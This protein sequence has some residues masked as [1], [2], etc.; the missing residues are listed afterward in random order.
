MIKVNE[1]TYESVRDVFIIDLG[2]SNRAKNC[3]LRSGI[4]TVGQLLEATREELIK[5]PNMG[6]GSLTEIETRLVQLIGQ[7][8]ICAE[9]VPDENVF[10]P[11]KRP[12]LDSDNE[13]LNDIPIEKLGL[14]AR[15]KH[16]LAHEGVKF[17]GQLRDIYETDLYHIQGMGSGSIKEIIDAVER[18]MSKPVYSYATLDNIDLLDEG[19]FETEEFSGL[20]EDK[21]KGMFE[22]KEDNSMS[23]FDIWN[24]LG[25]SIPEDVIRSELDK[26]TAKGVISL[27]DDSYHFEYP[28]IVDAI[29]VL[30]E[31]YQDVISLKL[32]GKKYA[33]IAEQYGVTRSRAQQMA[34]KGMT[35]VFKGAKG[36]VPVKRVKEDEDKLLF[37]TYDISVGEWVTNLKKPEHA[38]R[39]LA[40]RYKRGERPL[41]GSKP[42]SS[43]S[44]GTSTPKATVKKASINNGTLEDFLEYYRSLAG[45][46][47]DVIL[48][49]EEEPYVKAVTKLC[50]RINREITKKKYISDIR[51]TEQEYSMLRGYLHYAVKMLNKTGVAPDDAMFAAAMINVAIK[52]YREGNFWGNFFKEIQLNPNTN[53]QRNIGVKFYDV[54]EKYDLAR[55]DAGEYVQNILLH[56]F[57]SDYYAN[58]YFD[59]LF[60]FYRIDL[61]RDI[62]R[63]D[64]DTMRALMDSICSEENVG[65]TY[66]LVQHI[67]QAMAANRRGAT[68]RIR[69]H[70][71]LLDKFFWDDS[72]EINTTHRLNNLMQKWARS[73]AEVISEME[74]FSTGRRRG[75]KRFAAPF[76]AF[77]DESRECVLTIPAQSIKRYDTEEIFWKASGAI[78]RKFDVELSESV[79]G[80]KV[81]ES[82]WDIPMSL[83]LSDIQLE[84]MT[85][86]GEVIKRFPIKGAD[87][88]FFDDEGYPVNA[89]N[90]KVGEVVSISKENT[91][92]KSSALYDTD[93]IDGMLIS[94]FHF[95]FED[96]LRMPNGKVVI[97]GKPEITNSIAGKG[98]IE[99]AACQ[100][101]DTKYDLYGKVPY[102]VLR[103]KE[104]KFNGT[105]VTINGRRHRLG[106]L[107]FE[108]FTIDDRTGDSGYYVDLGSYLGE[109]DDL[110][111]ISVD[112]PGGATPHWEFVYIKGFEVSF[113]E[114]P[115]VFE[116]RGTV[117]FADH[118]EINDI[119]ESCER[120]PGV[121]GFKF[122]INDIGRNLAFNTT[123]GDKTVDI[124]VPV[125]AFF[126]RNADGEWDSRIPTPVWHADLPDVIDLSVPHHNIKLYM[127]DVLSDSG[128]TEREI[129][130]RK[131]Q[132]DDHILCD[133]TKFKSYLSGD[134]I[135]RQLRMRF[136]DVDMN[137]MTIIIHSK[138]ISLQIIGDYDANEMIVNADISGKAAYYVDIHKAGELIIEKAPLLN[139]TAKISHEIG[140]GIYEVEVFELVEDESGFG[141]EDYYSIGLYNQEMIN[142]YDMTDRS[143]RIIQIEGAENTSEILPLKL[144]FNVLDLK[145][146]DDNHLYNGT[147]VVKKS[148]YKGS[149]IAALPVTVRFDDLSQPNYAW[150]SFVDDEYGDEMDFLYDT[151]KQGILQEEN[152]SLKPM[153]CYRRYTF[154]NDE[155]HIYHIDFI[156]EHYS[157]DYD[158]LSEM[159]EYPE[160]D[161]KIHFRE[162]RFDSKRNRFE[163]K[164]NSR[165]VRIYSS[166]LIFIGD[167]PLQS[168]TKIC[169]RDARINTLNEIT[170]MTKADLAKR[171]SA[172]I[173][174]IRDIEKALLQYGMAFRKMEGEE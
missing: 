13:L 83:A 54:L 38:Y 30:P 123:V 100:L 174:I 21:I 77:D 109:R 125:P 91:E 24:G 42:V 68:I 9:E 89:K 41:P 138:V 113:E 32:Q 17:I 97:V 152:L 94:F 119:N 19:F 104:E 1:A 154:L 128:D 48:Y 101:N 75:A 135:A 102:L 98:R 157:S 127:D 27:S 146:T 137:L 118:I 121:N 110:Y 29:R 36:I 52:A 61:D 159:I 136:G 39:Y 15:A 69:N 87:V 46:Q 85:A 129:T 149:E 44:R 115:Y 170:K 57:V 49:T 90:I 66:M 133:I 116:P 72:F 112:I 155:E 96:I 163:L 5:I 62:S 126:I 147:M 150:I 47:R 2:L 11:S 10:E 16:G 64:T 34:A 82:M 173:Q 99:G 45:V 124:S 106:D 164:S 160:N 20:V 56:C 132:G 50:K 55:V 7:D 105:A 60:N 144:R 26:L 166:D 88:R 14:S 6:T 40:M 156:D 134:D 31:K 111:R 148:F 67:G 59:F 37:Q 167:A 122:E 168:K 143:F 80:Y 145:R 70:M 131:N 4:F 162:N 140:N 108:S 65:R 35:A 161:T 169:L 158:E 23:F 18:F 151:R 43:S 12:I 86:E 81:H 165:N 114:A 153:V 63:L 103:M 95:E 139:G 142:P 130:Y 33:E 120:E 93:I 3:L 172:N 84:L 107:D 74:T 58:S 28:S 76:I 79:I 73:S 117:V 71:K 25:A 51:I 53:H 78:N 171:S 8:N 22:L 92:I 141:G